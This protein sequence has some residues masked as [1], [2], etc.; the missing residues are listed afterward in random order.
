MFKAT[1]LVTVIGYAE[2]LTTVQAIYSRNFQTIPLLAVAVIWYLVLTSIAMF[3]QS[4]LER[5]FSR[6][7]SRRVQEQKAIADTTDRVG[8]L[9]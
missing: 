1:S 9:A 8:G 4:L 6:G 3:G 5:R 7:Y 2:L